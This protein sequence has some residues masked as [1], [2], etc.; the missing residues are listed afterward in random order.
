MGKVILIEIKS[1][2]LSKGDDSKKKKRA[3]KRKKERPGESEFH[4]KRTKDF[5][6]L[7][8]LLPKVW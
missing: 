1:K 8:F 2:D 4:N 7:G 5:F 3:E 6:P